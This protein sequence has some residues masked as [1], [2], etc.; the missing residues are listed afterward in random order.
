MSAVLNAVAYATVAVVWLAVLLWATD[1]LVRYV[2]RLF[3][4]RIDRGT[5]FYIDARSQPIERRDP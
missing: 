5:T 3:D 2:R 4:R 1:Y